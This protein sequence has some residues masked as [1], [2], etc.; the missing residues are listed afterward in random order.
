MASRWAGGQ[1]GGG[2]HLARWP[3][4]G[5]EYGPPEGQ[6]RNQRSAAE[7][8][9]NRGPPRLARPVASGEDHRPAEVA[10]D[11]QWKGRTTGQQWSRL[12][13]FALPAYLARPS[14]PSCPATS[15]GTTRQQSPIRPVSLPPTPHASRQSRSQTIIPRTSDVSGCKWVE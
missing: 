4:E 3:A 1:H 5:T 9:T 14:R 10:P 13:L 2:D 12:N 15:G 6:P 7:R 11:G 8:E